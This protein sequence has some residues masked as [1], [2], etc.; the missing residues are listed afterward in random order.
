MALPMHL[1]AS[2]TDAFEAALASAE[3]RGT[4]ADRA[5]ATLIRQQ[6]ALH[7]SYVH[8]CQTIERF[9]DGMRES[10]AHLVPLRFPIRLTPKTRECVE[11]GMF[12]SFLRFLED[13]HAAVL[14]QHKHGVDD[15]VTDT[16]TFLTK[17]ANALTLE[18]CRVLDGEASPCEAR[19]VCTSYIDKCRRAVVRQ[20]SAELLEL[21]SACGVIIDCL[22]RFDVHASKIRKR[23]KER[24]RD[25]LRAAERRGL[26][27][28]AGR[29]QRARQTRAL[30]ERHSWMLGGEFDDARIKRIYELLLVTHT[31]LAQGLM[32]Q[33]RRIA[34]L[35]SANA[36]NRC[37]S[38]LA[39]ATGIAD[40]RVVQA[41]A[42]MRS[43]SG[44]QR[45]RIVVETEET[46]FACLLSTVAVADLTVELL[47]ERYLPLNRISA[48]YADRVLTFDFCKYERAARNILEET[49][50]PWHERQLACELS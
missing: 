12:R 23:V 42:H 28:A 44:E 21:D 37:W 32:W 4:E 11:D 9:S 19:N 38:G 36:A 27:E 14:E 10:S 29:L 6:L 17:I 45:V 30:L 26:S 48:A 41:P 40:G 39:L 3:D 31:E 1:R 49:V 5:E 33:Q 15:L 20:E 18:S 43:L 16:A 24:L 35:A 46:P 22:R 2:E 8:V 34:W 7:A 50:R 25:F 47:H 13:L